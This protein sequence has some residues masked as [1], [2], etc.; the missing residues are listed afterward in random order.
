MNSLYIWAAMAAL[1]TPHLET[2]QFQMPDDYKSE[3]GAELGGGIASYYGN[4]F[5]GR[6]TASGETYRPGAY[7]AAHR[8]LPFGTR[9]VVTHAGNGRQVTVR[10]NDRGPFVRGRV[11]DLSYAAAQKIGLQQTGTAR[12]TLSRAD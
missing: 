5:A 12:V 11:I 1:M 9:I 3:R 2:P 7:T 10:V 4:K 6:R 8:T